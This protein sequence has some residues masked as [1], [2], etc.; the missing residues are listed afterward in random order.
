MTVIYVASVLKQKEES[1]RQVVRNLKAAGLVEEDG[2]PTEIANDWRDDERYGEACGAMLAVYPQ[3]LR[4]IAP[5]PKPDRDVVK[6][7]FMRARKVGSGAATNM[8]STY[9]LIASADL[10]RQKD[11]P[12]RA[13][14]SGTSAGGGDPKTPARKGVKQTGQV[15]EHHGLSLPQAQIA[16]QI[17]IDPTMTADQIDLVFASMA[18]HLYGS[19]GAGSA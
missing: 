13:T 9:L 12:R 5:G 10:G 16:V 6:N 15:V 1:A 4:E 18:K 17:N 19:R 7:W 2:T 3:E 14:A 11:A 8:A